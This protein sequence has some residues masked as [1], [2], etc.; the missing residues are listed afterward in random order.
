MIL[1]ATV[2]CSASVHVAVVKVLS[3]EPGRA[4]VTA[5]LDAFFNVRLAPEG[6]PIGLLANVPLTSSIVSVASLATNAAA[7]LSEIVISAAA[8]FALFEISGA[9]EAENV[10]ASA[11]EIFATFTLAGATV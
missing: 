10:K 2:D 4:V 6:V 8:W 7:L 5:S 3:S 9:A 1:P 11:A